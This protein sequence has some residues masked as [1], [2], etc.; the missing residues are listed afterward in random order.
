MCD[1]A[2]TVLAFASHPGEHHHEK[3]HLFW[4]D[5]PFIVAQA[6]LALG[7]CTAGAEACLASLSGACC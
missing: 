3:P 5:S 4:S 2:R 1:A 6:L 7:T